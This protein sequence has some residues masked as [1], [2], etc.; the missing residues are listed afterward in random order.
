MQQS[1]LFA[2]PSIDRAFGLSVCLQGA[3]LFL[4]TL[5]ILASFG[6]ATAA[7]E[8]ITTWS[9]SRVHPL[10]YNGRTLTRDSLGNY[11]MVMRGGNEINV[12]K[13][14]AA[15]AQWANLGPINDTALSTGEG[16]CAAIAVDGHNH[17]HVVFYDGPAPNLVHKVSIDGAKFEARHLVQSVV[18]WQTTAAGGPFLHVD[19]VNGLH[20]A[21]VDESANKPYYAF[22]ADGGNTWDANKVSDLGGGNLRPSVTTSQGGRVFVGFSSPG[23]RS[24]YSDNRG[25]TWTESSPENAAAWSVVNCRLAASDDTVYVTGQKISPE[26]RAIVLSRTRGTTVS[27]SPWE[28]ISSGTGAD[29]SLY[30]ASGGAPE[31]LWRTYPATPNQLHRS[32]KGVAWSPTTLTGDDD[33]IFPYVYWQEYH[34]WQPGANKVSLLAPDLT[35]R[36]VFFI[37]LDDVTY[38]PDTQNPVP[39]SGKSRTAELKHFRAAF[40]SF[41]PGDREL[42]LRVEIPRHSEESS[43]SAILSVEIFDSEGRRILVIRRPALGSGSMDLPI[44][45]PPGTSSAIGKKPWICRVGLGS[46]Q[47]VLSV[48]SW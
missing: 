3:G 1:T 47:T 10:S 16:D 39:V 41:I 25:A 24:A 18:T 20:V 26:P 31:V 40:R 7:P 21:F 6:Q 48:P 43:G 27:W 12:W 46:G 30:L 13:R 44:R 2:I 14:T 15:N 32:R 11:Y 9:T 5:L 29:A 17:I 22:S 8:P 38:L 35:H 23:F 4:A 34:R 28:L 19:R 36:Q 33:Y 45:F 42:L 37:Q